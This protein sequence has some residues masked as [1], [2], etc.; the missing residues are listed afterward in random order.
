MSEKQKDSL[1][2]FA[3]FHNPTTAH[4]VRSI[5]E[6]HDIPC[7]VMDHM[8]GSMNWDINGAT[9]LMIMESD[10]ETAKELLAEEDINIE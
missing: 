4:L 8:N 5:L 9:R 2:L 3:R 7:F 10:I 1:T 6:S